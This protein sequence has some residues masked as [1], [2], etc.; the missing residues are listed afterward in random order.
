MAAFATSLQFAS[1][2]NT[3]VRAAGDVTAGLIGGLAAGTIIGAAVAGP[4]Y[5]APP[6]VFVAHRPLLASSLGRD[7]VISMGCGA[8]MIGSAIFI[9]QCRRSS[10]ATWKLFGDV[11][12]VGCVLRKPQA[13]VK[14]GFPTQ[15]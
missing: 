4:R 14:S 1:A 3:P 13:G 9:G 8:P 12:A 11:L 7:S 5:D 10:S 6:P 15:T 2:A